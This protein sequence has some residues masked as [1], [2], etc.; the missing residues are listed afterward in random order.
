MES[1]PCGCWWNSETGYL[2]LCPDHVTEF[3][4]AAEPRLAERKEE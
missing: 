2:E 1:K 4:A 3:I